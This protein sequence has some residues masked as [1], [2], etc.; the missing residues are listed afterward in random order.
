MTRI[1]FYILAGAQMEQRLNFACRWVQKAQRNGSSVYIAVENQRQ[2]DYMDQLLWNFTPESFVAHDCDGKGSLHSPVTIGYSE[3]CG[4]H[5]HC[6]VN[7]R[8]DIPDYFSRFERLTEI[9]CQHEKVLTESRE[10]YNFYRHR[11]YPIQSH[12]LRQKPV[13]N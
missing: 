4:E 9:V 11:G 5:H 1:D 2:A 3:D 12:D 13:S 8:R 10:R 7:L 6:L